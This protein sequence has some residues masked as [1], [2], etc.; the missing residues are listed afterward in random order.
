MKKILA[1]LAVLCLM[2]C[3]TTAAETAADPATAAAAFAQTVPEAMYSTL[4]SV[5][6]TYDVIAGLETTVI[7]QAP[8]GPDEVMVLIDMGN[9]EVMLNYMVGGRGV[10][11]IVYAVTD[12]ECTGSMY[13]E[14]TAAFTEIYGDHSVAGEDLRYIFSMISMGAYDY[15]DPA[16]IPAWTLEDGTQVVLLANPEDPAS[17]AVYYISTA[18]FE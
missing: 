7:R 9:S 13:D 16:E 2:L 3:F 10:M 5:I 17:A 14:L 4:D 18:F 15:K 12:F 6:L 1:L 11:A 8:E